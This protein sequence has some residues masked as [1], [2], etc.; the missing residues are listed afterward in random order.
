MH[1]NPDQF[2]SKI[3]F[4]LA[5]A[6]S[7]VG[8]GNLVGFPVAAAKN[9]GGAF[10]LLYIFFVVAI[11]LP[12]ILAELSL[13]RAT[14]QSPL[15]AF[16]QV[17]KNSKIWA[18]AGALS[19]ITPF[20]IAV[21]YSV[22]TVWLLGYF[23]QVLSGR[24]DE[25]ATPVYFGGFITSPWIFAY[26]A[27]VIGMVVLVLK[28][29][30]R[31]GIEKAARL[32]MPMLFIMLIGLAVF[33]LTLPN[34]AAG[35]KFY[36]T[37]QLDRITWSVVNGALSQAFFSL[38]LG[39]GILITY[40]SYLRKQD[41][42]VQSAK[43]LACTDTGVALVAGL[44]TLPAI[45]AIYPSTNPGELSDSS[46]GLIFSFFPNIFMAM[47]PKFGYLAASFV[48]ATFFLLAFVAAITSLVSI[49]EVPVAALKAESKQTRNKALTV[50]ITG[51]L[52]GAVFSAL[53]FGQVKWLS[54][55][56]F[57][58]GMNKSLFDVLV[59]VFYDTIL[60]FNGLLI[61]LLV[62]WQWKRHNM[63]AEMASGG[64][65]GWLERYTH[66]AIAFWIPA[67][68]ATVFVVTVINKFFS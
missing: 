16:K 59:D 56:A 55:F 24:L 12:L 51:V 37:P 25:L 50:V 1:N 5:A 44:M 17:S 19:L 43:M 3:G 11:C 48:A 67:I 34:A 9:G 18:F 35:L 52:L 47:V 7:A 61:C 28:G 62:V 29:G 27:A 36:F 39:M 33:V 23:L 38:S 53:S 26:L 65:T 41:N 32:L 57:Y 8:I 14:G 10:L 13:G 49:I 40:G 21:F 15:G 60:P 45:F 68:L 22:L 42:L 6:G 66:A 30:V 46:V 20:M 54:E 4:V 64:A 2:S 58:S 63:A 31:D